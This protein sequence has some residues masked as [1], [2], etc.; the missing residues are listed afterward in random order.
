MA[1]FNKVILVG[2]LTRDPDLRV[3]PSGNS[4]CNIGLAVSRSYTTKD[5]DK[6]EETAFIDVDSFGRQ[7]EIINQYFSKGRP[8]MIEGRLKFGQWE[9]KDG[10][11]RSKL[12]VIMESFQFLGGKNDGDGQSSNASSESSEVVSNDNDS[13]EDESIDEVP[14]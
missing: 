8:I 5:G 2:N 4:V 3:T 7:A 14:F 1:S 13:K 6:K 12:S 11:K 10:E 9:S